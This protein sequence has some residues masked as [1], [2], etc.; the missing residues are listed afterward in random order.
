MKGEVS[1]K[2]WWRTSSAMKKHC[3]E[4]MKRTRHADEI[5]TRDVVVAGDS[6]CIAYDRIQFVRGSVEIKCRSAFCSTPDGFFASNIA[7]DRG[8]GNHELNADL[9]ET[10]RLAGVWPSQAHS[11]QKEE[12]PTLALSIGGSDVFVEAINDTWR[13]YDFYLP[14]APDLTDR[15][16]RCLQLDLV[17]DWIDHRLHPL[18]PALECLRAAGFCDISVLPPP[19]PHRSDDLR[20]AHLVDRGVDAFVAPFN[21]FAKISLL[22]RDGIRRIARAQKVNFFDTW[23]V[24]AEGYTLRP[25]YELDG[26]HANQDFARAVLPLLFASEDKGT[27]SPQPLST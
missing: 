4:D 15:S 18:G 14:S 9:I 6:H 24:A 22:Y 12:P 11:R 19:P 10:L 25:E 2:R 21:V 5:N 23:A 26:F 27:N 16:R 1:R 8:S 3:N 13:D 20:R 7:F 17:K